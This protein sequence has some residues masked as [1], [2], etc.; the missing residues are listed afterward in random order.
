[1]KSVK[2]LVT[3]NWMRLAAS[4]ILLGLVNI[5]TITVVEVLSMERT[6]VQLG[7]AP[8]DSDRIEES[9]RP[10]IKPCHVCP[11]DRPTDHLFFLPTEE[12]IDKAMT[13][14]HKRLHVDYIY[15]AWDC[16]DQAFELRVLMHRWFIDN[17]THD[18]PIASPVFIVY[19]RIADGIFGMS[20]PPSGG[21]HAMCVALDSHGIWW[22]IE[23]LRN[24]AMPLGLA[25]SLGLIEV[26]KI[27]W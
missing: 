25:K 7:V 20:L 6:P 4:I 15:E 14:C 21:M 18:A 16:D 24:Q 5:F 12:Q 10:Y 26:Q 3:V 11:T 8:I 9:F 2:P 27:I 22:L 17:V 1:M 19:A 13:E 23:P